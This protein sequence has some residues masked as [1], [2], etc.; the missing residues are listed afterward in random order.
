[1]KIY[2]NHPQTICIHPVKWRSESPSHLGG[3]RRQR[4][5]PPSPQLPLPDRNGHRKVPMAERS[6]KF[7]IN[8]PQNICIHPIKGQLEIP[9]HIGVSLI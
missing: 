9:S 5:T 7:D 4:R 2:I 8:H 1:M 3:N 6:I